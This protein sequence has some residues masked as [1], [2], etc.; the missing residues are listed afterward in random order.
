MIILARV[1]LKGEPMAM[2]SICR[3]S[4]PFANT[5]R[6]AVRQHMKQTFSGDTFH[7]FIMFTSQFKKVV[8]QKH[9]S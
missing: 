1:G 3:Q 2:P 7:Y 5:L 8:L 4:S 6:L 9:N